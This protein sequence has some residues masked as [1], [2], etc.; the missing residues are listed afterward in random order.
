MVA[1]YE[2]FEVFKANCLMSYRNQIQNEC[3]SIHNVFDF[4]VMEDESELEEEP[5]S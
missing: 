3:N 4:C 1:K 2:I 5:S